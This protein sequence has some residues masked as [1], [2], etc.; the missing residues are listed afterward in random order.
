M[1]RH[2]VPNIIIGPPVVRA[3]KRIATRDVHLM[4][5]DPDRQID[6]FAAAGANMLAVHVGPVP[7]LHRRISY[8][9]SRGVKSGAVVNRQRRSVRWKRSCAVTSAASPLATDAQLARGVPF[10]N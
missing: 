3:I 1:D 6:D 2:F 7:Q 4:I 5:E 10:F 8:I 9:K